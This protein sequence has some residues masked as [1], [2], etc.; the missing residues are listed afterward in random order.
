MSDVLHLYLKQ[1]ARD[2]VVFYRNKVNDCNHRF[3]VE[4]LAVL[5][6]YIIYP[7]YYNYYLP[8]S[9]YYFREYDLI[10]LWQI[11]DLLDFNY[12]ITRQ[13]RLDLWFPF[14][15]M[16]EQALSESYDDWIE[17]E[18]AKEKFPA[19]QP[20][21][22]MFRFEINSC[23]T[24]SQYELFTMSRNPRTSEPFI[25]KPEMRAYSK[26]QKEFRENAIEEIRKSKPAGLPTKVR[27][28]NDLDSFHY[29][30][31]EHKSKK[32][33]HVDYPVFFTVILQ[34][35]SKPSLNY[36][37][38]TLSFLEKKIQLEVD[39]YYESLFDKNK[40]LRKDYNS[41]LF[42]TKEQ[43]FPFIGQVLFIINYY[44]FMSFF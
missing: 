22:N 23:I 21:L 2:L 6:K 34:D 37:E 17:T 27:N 15:D 18:T 9:D 20:E 8:I 28:W 16:V 19:F 44:L 1:Y 43:C 35:Y 4:D 12:M 32:H 11:K 42:K 41:K 40:R 5:L 39:V 25:T 13:E 31:K 3:H 10:E 33:A 14:D 26:Q 29:E 36:E 24:M 30:K 38:R 7:L